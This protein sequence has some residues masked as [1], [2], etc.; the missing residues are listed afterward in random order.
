MTDQQLALEAIS[1]APLILEEYLQ[2]RPQNNERIFHKLVEFECPDWYSLKPIAARNISECS[3]GQA[4]SIDC[5]GRFHCYAL[6]NW[7]AERAG[8]TTMQRL[9]AIKSAALVVLSLH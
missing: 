8:E 4:N 3:I 5:F 2:P 6:I 9:D 1:E 7:N